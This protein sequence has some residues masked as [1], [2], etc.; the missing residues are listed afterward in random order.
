[1]M[2][3]SIFILGIIIMCIIATKLITQC[4]HHE[5]KDKEIITIVEDKADA[6]ISI[7]YPKTNIEELDR[8]IESDIVKQ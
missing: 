2:K 7:H 4:F 1:M 5:E 3:K 8:E 6:V